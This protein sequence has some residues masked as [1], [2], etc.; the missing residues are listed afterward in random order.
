MKT[1]NVIFLLIGGAIVYYILTSK[2]DK[3][4]E[5]IDPNDVSK[6]DDAK[7]DRYLVESCEVKKKGL[8]TGTHEKAL[9]FD[10]VRKE[11]IKRNLNIPKCAVSS[12]DYIDQSFVC[13]KCAKAPC[14]CKKLGIDDMIK[15]PSPIA[16]GDMPKCGEGTKFINGRCLPI[17]TRPQ[18]EYGLRGRAIKQG[19]TQGIKEI[20]REK[21]AIKQ[22]PPSDSYAFPK[23]I[24]PQGE[25]YTLQNA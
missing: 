2:K 12:I 8:I 23:Y 22:M 18:P 21:T 7:I 1:S 15:P 4:Q 16:T 24:N 13:P 14:K 6:W 19:R 20:K 11:A 10:A 9:L 5:N 3:P 25:G 17:N